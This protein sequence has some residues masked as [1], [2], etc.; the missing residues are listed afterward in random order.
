MSEVAKE[1]NKENLPFMLK[2]TEVANILRMRR[3]DA[4]EVLPRLEGFPHI[5]LSERR[6]RIPRD[7]FFAWLEAQGPEALSGLRGKRKGDPR[8]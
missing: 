2:M 8:E 7:A 1:F 4:Y 3:Q 6:M 5:K